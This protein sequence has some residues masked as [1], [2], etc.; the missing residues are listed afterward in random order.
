MCSCSQTMMRDSMVEFAV[1][2]CSR[3]PDFIDKLL[4]PFIEH[5]PIS[6]EDCLALAMTFDNFSDPHEFSKIFVDFC[7]D[8]AFLLDGKE[9]PRNTD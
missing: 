3:V 5:L 2:F 9:I 4:V 8:V 6:K 7:N 1:F